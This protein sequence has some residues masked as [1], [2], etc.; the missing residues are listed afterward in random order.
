M[1]STTFVGLK[2]LHDFLFDIP[3]AI[4][5]HDGID[6]LRRFIFYTDNIRPAH[7]ALTNSEFLNS[8][9]ARGPDACG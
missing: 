3:K 4:S 2:Y 5:Y 1:W 9:L 6:W 8:S 7:A